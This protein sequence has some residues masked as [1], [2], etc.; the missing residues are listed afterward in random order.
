MVAWLWTEGKSVYQYRLLVDISIYMYAFAIHNACFDE[1]AA[2]HMLQDDEM[3]TIDE[4][5]RRRAEN[6]ILNKS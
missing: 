3:M 1:R 5:T 2:R 6:T 4:R